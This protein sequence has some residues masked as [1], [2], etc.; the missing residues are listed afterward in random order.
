MRAADTA[1]YAAK[2]LGRNTF[3]FYTDAFLARV[4]RRLTVE[5]ELRTALRHDE[6]R[7]QYQPT[8]NVKTAKTVGIEAFLRWTTRSEEHT[9]ELQ[10]LMRI[11]YAVFCLKNKNK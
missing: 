4:Q 7:L 8:L 1:M 9:S 3:Q 6:F 2:D 10:S 11:P 5:N